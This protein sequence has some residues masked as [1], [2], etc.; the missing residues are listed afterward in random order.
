MRF[1]GYVRR[2]TDRQEQ[3]LEGQRAAC[4]A[5]AT[6]LGGRIE[7]GDFFEDDAVTGSDLQR[8][9]LLA[10]LRACERRKDVSGVVVWDRS[11]LARATDPRAAL[12]LELEIENTGK[13]IHYVN[14]SCQNDGSIGSH[15]VALVESENAGRYL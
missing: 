1:F 7:E 12:A 4:E 5:L 10:L 2:S 6:K 14:S 9:G 15:I 11:R 3:S 8:P 13:R